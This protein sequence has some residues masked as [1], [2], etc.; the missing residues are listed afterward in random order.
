MKQQLAN[1]KTMLYSDYKL[2]AQL[3]HSI[4]VPNF[5]DKFLLQNLNPI[6]PRDIKDSMESSGKYVMLLSTI[7]VSNPED[8]ELLDKL[9]LAVNFDLSNLTLSNTIKALKVLEN[10]DAIRVLCNDSVTSDKFRVFHDKIKFV[11]S[12]YF[13]TELKRI[14]TFE[15][16]SSSAHSVSIDDSKELVID[17]T[18]EIDE[19]GFINLNHSDYGEFGR[20]YTI[21]YNDFATKMAYAVIDRPYVE[22]EVIEDDV[23]NE[24]P[25][26]KDIIAEMQ[27]YL[28]SL[29][30]F[31]FNLAKP[32]PDV[33]YENGYIDHDSVGNFR[34]YVKDGEKGRFLIDKN[35]WLLIGDDEGCPTEDPES[36]PI[37]GEKS[38]IGGK[39]YLWKY[40]IE[41]SEFEIPK[42]DFEK[43]FSYY[44]YNK[45]YLKDGIVNE[46]E[47][48][49]Y[50]WK[51]GQFACDSGNIN[52]IWDEE[53]TYY[54][55]FIKFEGDRQEFNENRYLFSNTLRT[56]FWNILDLTQ[57]KT[58]CVEWL[59]RHWIEI[60]KDIEI[61]KSTK[62]M[63]EIIYHLLSMDDFKDCVIM[64][65][66]KCVETI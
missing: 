13:D 40:V 24:T 64:K 56:Y 60:D 57:L 10:S 33:Y 41:D 28:P 7:I 19:E 29:K 17:N 48:Q 18:I 35:C 42:K 15:T 11:N 23:L 8:I 16:N 32:E 66:M 43:D 54:L 39:P 36:L 6:F 31:K 58:E 52:N 21:S 14:G 62:S 51:I 22:N 1:L 44:S 4:E 45:L 26:F 38:V 30:G 63:K 2:F 47:S 20:G 61:I 59:E 49:F 65:R 9:P 37:Y 53:K 46:F 5:S 27:R 12:I 25:Y 55:F 50:N 3:I 34:N